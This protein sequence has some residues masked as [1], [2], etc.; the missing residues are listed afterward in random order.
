LLN[1]CRAAGVSISGKVATAS[2]IALNGASV[3]LSSPRIGTVVVITDASGNY[4]FRDLPTDDDYTITA[5]W[6][7]FVFPTVTVSRP[8]TD[9]VI[10]LTGGQLQTAVRGRIADQHGG[11][12]GVTVNLFGGGL[13]RTTQT[14]ADGRYA[15]AG[16]Q[17]GGTYSLG[18][19]ASPIFDFPSPFVSIFVGDDGFVHDPFVLR[20]SYV[21]AGR[22]LTESGAPLAGAQLT[23]RGAVGGS[24]TTDAAGFYAFPPVP[25]GLNVTVTPAANDFTFDP[26][27]RSHFLVAGES[28]RDFTAR[29]NLP[30]F[31]AAAY[32]FGEG[33]GR[34][35][36]RV[37]RAGDLSRPETI[38][39]ATVDD[40]AAVRCDT[41]N[42]TAYARCDYATTVER[43]DFG[44]GE[45]EK[46][47][48][49]P[50][51]DDAHVEGA[52]TVR[53]RLF[54]PSGAGASA[55]PTA[56]LT[57]NDNDA[58]PAANPVEGNA[59]FVRQHYLDF[60]SRE[61]EAGEPWT[62]VLARCPNVHNDPECDRNLVSSA[63]F[64]SPE[65]ALKGRFVFQ[66]YKAAFGRLPEYAEIVVDM[67]S[68]AGRDQAEVFQKRAAFAQDF[69]AR[70]EFAQAYGQMT[71]QQFVDALLGRYGLQ[72]ITTEDPQSPE[73]P[74]QVTLTRRQLVD[75]LTGGALTRAKA[76]RAV[77]QSSEADAREFNGAFVAMQYYGY[78]RRT[79]EQS[80]YDAWLRVIGQ[81]PS[82]V[83]IMIDG[84]MNSQEYRLRFGQP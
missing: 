57:I 24:A 80:G 41:A 35:A 31:D 12:P 67:R 83:R 63:F 18:F 68:V 1:G 66:F 50:L 39:V 34:A 72:Q 47:F 10:N 56:T 40:G 16:V 6:P 65:F 15:F 8:A 42:G 48:A 27:S 46:S 14:D 5:W 3:R 21:I 20:K 54:S 76:L 25:A 78:L 36:F 45:T 23:M 22:V 79:P 26:A 61:P 70:Q 7:S 32:Q 58:A 33:D 38:F 28:G 29:R 71:H 77:V 4:A 81:D 2:G 84:F 37:T 60:L 49:V 13:T 11:S 55:Q 82:N 30:R 59:F 19:P 52:E 69:A 64:Q 17:A 75:G 53:V 44:P 43:L 62:G 9:R 51:I 73:G 74:A